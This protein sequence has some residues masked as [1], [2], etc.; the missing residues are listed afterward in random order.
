LNC[1]FK[2][3]FCVLERKMHWDE[4]NILA[5]YHPH[6]KDYGFMKVNEPSTPYHHPCEVMSDDEGDGIDADKLQKQ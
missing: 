6:D 5:T 3:L 1:L 4:M 2:R